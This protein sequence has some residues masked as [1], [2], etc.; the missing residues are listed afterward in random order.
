MSVVEE[1]SSML[2]SDSVLF[3]EEFKQKSPIEKRK[4]IS[5]LH[6]QFGHASSE[7]MKGLL[8]PPMAKPFWLTNLAGGGGWWL[9]PP[10]LTLNHCL[11]DRLLI[12]NL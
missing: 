2:K 11:S 4:I 10:S 8:S 12:V 7:R 9:P 5:K 3:S 6:Q 1:D